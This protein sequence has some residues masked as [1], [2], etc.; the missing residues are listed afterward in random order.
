MSQDSLSPHE[1]ME[2][3]ELLNFKTVCLIKSRLMNGPVSDQNLKTLLE[4]DIQQAS[5][6]AADLQGLLSKAPKLQ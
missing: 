5:K 4:K 2:I 6:A 3:Q 1:T